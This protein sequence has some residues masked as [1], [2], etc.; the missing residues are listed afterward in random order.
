MTSPC[1][2]ERPVPR[3]SHSATSQAA[4]VV[5]ESFVAPELVAR[6]RPEGI[7]PRD[8]RDVSPD[9][10]KG[11]AMSALSPGSKA[12]PRGIRHT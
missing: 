9:G 4:E 1:A 5:G 11:D 3:L 10:V 12:G 6:P 2:G 7:T 8:R